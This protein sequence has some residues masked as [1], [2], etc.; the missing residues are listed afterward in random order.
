MLVLGT[1]ITMGVALASAPTTKQAP[2]PYGAANS[3]TRFVS[4]SAPGAA[5][6]GP[7]AP[8]APVTY[9]LDD[10]TIDR[11]LG[12]GNNALTIG[13]AYIWLNR[14]TPAVSDF[15]VT[16]Q[17]VS[18]YWPRTVAAKV[19]LVGKQVK[20]LVY[21]DSDGDDN[22][23]N[24]V[25]LEEQLVT[26]GMTSTFETYPVNVQVL[27]PGDIYVGFESYFA[28]QHIS[29]L[30][31]PASVDTSTN[32]LR[33]WI[34]G[35]DSG[36]PPDID[37][38]GNNDYQLR[39]SDIIAGNLM[40]RANGLTE[41]PGNTGCSPQV[42]SIAPQQP[43]NNSVTAKRSVNGGPRFDGAGGANGSKPAP[44]APAANTITDTFVVDDGTREAV[45][46]FGSDD[47]STGY[48]AIWLNRFTPPLPTHYPFTVRTISIQ[49]P[50]PDWAY[51][52]LLN[53]QITLLVYHDSDGDGDPADAVLLYQQLA[54]IPSADL[55]VDYSV[56]VTVPG[57]GDIYVGFESTFA[58]GPPYP[59]PAPG[60]ASFDQNSG[61][62]GRSY[63]YGMQEVDSEPRDPNK[64]NLGANTIGGRMDDLGLPGNFLIRATGLA[65]TVACTATPT[66][67][68]TSTSTS[69]STATRTSTSTSTA[70]STSTST[71]VPS[72]TTVPSST[73]TASATACTISYSDVDEY[74]PFYV[75]IKCLTCQN[76]VSGFGDGTF[77]PGIE[78]SRG[79]ASKMVSNAAGFNETVSG[80]T[81]PDVAP[82]HTYYEFIERLAQRGLVGGFPDGMF[83]PERSITRGQLAKVVSNAA[84]FN[85]T[86]PAGTQSF[87]DVLPGD[88]YYV[89]IERLS[90]RGVVHGYAC[91]TDPAG[92]CDSENRHYYLPGENITRGQAA[93]VISGTFFPENCEPGRPDLLRP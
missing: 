65:N 56:N 2:K 12:F 83:R 87:T 44:N 1:F 7:Q 79:Q 33:S 52:D 72:N 54:T 27:G 58:K 60:P 50:N 3:Q 18:I 19:E 84:G 40:I 88:T 48:A 25:L 8:E 80:Q 67:T 35:E 22:P 70:T 47:L 63:A 49:W 93:K 74:D 31:Y 41:N 14:F 21:Q 32:Q 11:V 57:P 68:S 51:T 20:L 85:D 37:N 45:V 28:E 64:E 38:L 82:G 77:R 71:S 16:L 55:F 34:F 91:G 36:N 69:T 17:S 6:S 39:L 89:W 26:I 86:P 92:P 43:A 81:F 29:P 46:R 76:I 61:S 15:P 66:V 62:K 53:K 23:A 30:P 42:M 9:Q 13:Y 10:G 90:R 59:Q 73:A 4:E 75:F 5:Q 78:V 24:A